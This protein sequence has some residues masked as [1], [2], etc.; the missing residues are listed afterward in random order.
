MGETN[1]MASVSRKD[2]SGLARRRISVRV[3]GAEMPLVVSALPAMRAGA[4]SMPS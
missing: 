4:P 2:S 1:G 3:S